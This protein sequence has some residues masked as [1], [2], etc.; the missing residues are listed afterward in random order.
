MNTPRGLHDPLNDGAKAGQTHH[1]S[2]SLHL[3][4]ARSRPIHAKLLF[5]QLSQMETLIVEVGGQHDLACVSRVDLQA[6]CARR[7]EL[8]IQCRTDYV[9]LDCGE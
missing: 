7:L 1:C 3:D 2:S 4:R 9:D 5:W 6:E 8:N